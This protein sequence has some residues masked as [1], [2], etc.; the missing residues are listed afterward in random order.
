MAPIEWEPLTGDAT[1]SETREEKD[2]RRARMFPGWNDPLSEAAVQTL[3]AIYTKALALANGIVR[4]GLMPEA[5]GKDYPG[6]KELLDKG[7]VI[8]S[9]LM[10]AILDEKSGPT[11]FDTG[12]SVYCLGGRGRAY[13][14]EH[15]FGDPAGG[16]GVTALLKSI[17]G[18]NEPTARELAF[19]KD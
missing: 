5:D 4:R 12:S 14:V 17:T 18:S 11:F 13:A 7:Y 1:G 8:R 16:G 9:P 10:L 19:G 15:Q 3:K 6:L 2:A